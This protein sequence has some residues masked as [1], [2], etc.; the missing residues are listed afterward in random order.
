ME[1]FSKIKKMVNSNFQVVA[2]SFKMHNLIKEWNETKVGLMFG[3]LFK[4]GLL[5][6]LI[7]LRFVLE[8]LQ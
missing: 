5:T 1:L 8:V 7:V 2:G 4:E 3:F 6:I